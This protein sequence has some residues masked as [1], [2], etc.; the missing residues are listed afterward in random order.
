MHVLESILSAKRRIAMF[1]ASCLVKELGNEYMA[2]GAMELSI[3]NAERERIEGVL[4]SAGFDIEYV[5]KIEHADASKIREELEYKKQLKELKL[6]KASYPKQNELRKQIEVIN[7]ELESIGDSRPLLA[8]VFVKVF[9]KEPS[10]ALAAKQVIANAEN[11]AN[12]L[13]GI[14]GI[15]CR[16]LKGKELEALFCVGNA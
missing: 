13:A 10:A 15:E 14:E 12:E 8:R 2:M 6:A 9:A 3:N 4:A 11:L 16:M 1:N 5:L 7:G